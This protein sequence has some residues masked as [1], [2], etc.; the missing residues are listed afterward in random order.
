MT[1]DRQRSPWLDHVLLVLAAAGALLLL[2]GIVA[3]FGQADQFDLSANERFRALGGAANPFVGF[4][5]LVVTAGVMRRRS[6][7]TNT[8][9]GTDSLAL[10]VSI[11]VALVTV[12]LGLNGVI[13]TLASGEFVLLMRLGEAMQRLGATLLAAYALL[14]AATAPT[15]RGSP[16]AESPPPSPPDGEDPESRP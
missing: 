10:V 8:N 1:D 3:A 15:Q 12:L 6:P 14:L 13:S 4:L 11:C 16:P 5:T 2:T 7:N 9:S